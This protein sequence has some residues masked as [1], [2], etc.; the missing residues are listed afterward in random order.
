MPTDSLVVG[1]ISSDSFAES[2]KGL[3]LLLQRDDMT[4][5]QIQQVAAAC[6]TND[7]IMGSGPA[8]KLL[9]GFYKKYRD[10]LPADLRT[11]FAPDADRER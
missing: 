5:D 8:Q 4:D 7:Q 11:R 1:V 9:P 10:R 3:G 2:G 6:L